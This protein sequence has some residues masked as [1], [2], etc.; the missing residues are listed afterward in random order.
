MPKKYQKIDNDPDS[1]DDLKEALDAEA[2]AP[3]TDVPSVPVEL[4]SDPEPIKVPR[5][6]KNNYVIEPERVVEAIKEGK[7]A[8][9]NRQVRKL[10]TKPPKEKRVL[11]DE[12]RQR[13]LKQLAKGR[14]TI[15]KNKLLH[16]DTARQELIKR[17]EALIAEKM[18]SVVKPPKGR[19]KNMKPLLEKQEDQ[20]EE[21]QP[22][23]PKEEKLPEPEPAPVKKF[24]RR[25]MIMS[26]D[27]E[28]GDTTDTTNIK[29]VRRK[30]RMVKEAVEPPAAPVRSYANLSLVEKLL[31]KM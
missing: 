19:P 7:V 2:P 24:G 12:E 27:T 15:A 28:D 25:H 16:G 23:P 6:Y 14:E 22:E 13:L 31:A 30:I 8:L 20:K 9:T 11:C 1:D 18:L 21:K 10:I 29:R 4:P 17:K 3:D 26:S 5:K